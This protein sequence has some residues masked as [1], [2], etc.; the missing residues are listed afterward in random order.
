MMRVP[1]RATTFPFATAMPNLDFTLTGDY[2]ELHNLL[3]L[4]ALADSGGAAKMLVASG[5]VTVDGR[6]ELRKTCK[7]RAGQVVLVGD[8]RIAVHEDT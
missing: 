8:T 2:V 7:I 1:F 5:A 4:T 6:V 3:K